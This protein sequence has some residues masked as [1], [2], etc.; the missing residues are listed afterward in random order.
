V[1]RA[2]PSPP[3]GRKASSAGGKP[4][5]T[6]GT[7]SATGGKPSAN[8]RKPSPAAGGPSTPARTAAPPAVTARAPGL[9]DDPVAAI[10]SVLERAGKAVGAGAIKQGLVEA[11]ASATE[12][13][14]AWDRSREKVRFHEHVDYDGRTYRYTAQPRTLTPNEALFHLARGGTAAERAAWLAVIEAALVAD[15]TDTTQLADARTKIAEAEQRIVALETE[16]AQ[17]AQTPSAEQESAEQKSAGQTPTEKTDESPHDQYDRAERRRAARERQARIDAMS[18]VAELAAEVEEL[19]AKR[20]SAEVL[21]EH[22]RALTGDRGLEA[23]GRAGETSP[24]DAKRHDP[25]GDV[26]DEG[27]PVIVIRPGYLWHAPGEA[28]LISRALVSRK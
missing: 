9:A 11:G 8:G 15:V 24:Y 3:P 2:K 13:G 20:A 23:I 25:V 10:L 4:S 5:A 26:P 17:R 18:T 1:T 12:A 7:P 22:T 27:E 28:V 6:G 14:R 16:L 19:T 21:L